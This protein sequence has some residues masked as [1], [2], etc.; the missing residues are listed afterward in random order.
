L[1]LIVHSLDVL[2]YLKT[3]SRNSFG[4]LVFLHTQIANQIAFIVS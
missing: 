4:T 2:I 1:L 3:F